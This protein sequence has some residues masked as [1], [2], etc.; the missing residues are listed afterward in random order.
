[1]ANSL[2][3]VLGR[4]VRLDRAS[5]LDLATGDRVYL[6]AV[7][8]GDGA[9]H[10]RRAETAAHVSALRIAGM[11]PLVDYGLDGGGEWIEAY[12]LATADAGGEAA[13]SHPPPALGALLHAGGCEMVAVP[14]ADRRHGP[15][16]APFVPMPLE[17]VTITRPEVGGRGRQPPVY[18]GT[19]A[20]ATALE[21]RDELDG[22]VEWLRESDAGP[23]ARILRVEA[24]MGAGRRT[25]FEGIA[26]EVRLAGFVPVSSLLCR[27]DILSKAGLGGAVLTSALRERHIAV[28]EARPSASS[29]EVAR[30]L[31]RLNTSGGR[32]HALVVCG[33]ATG[34][35]CAVS[36]GP[37]RAEQL[38]RSVLVAGI[39]EAR[40][41]GAIDEALGRSGGWPGAFSRGVRRALGLR[42]PVERYPF[43]RSAPALVREGAPEVARPAALTRDDGGARAVARAEQWV[44]R[45]RHATAERLLRRTIGYLQ[46][47]RRAG[48]EARAQIALGRLLLARERRAGARA[49]FDASRRRF[50]QVRDTAGVVLA[51][52]HQGHASIEDGAL[53][54]A[55]SVLR[56]AE[57][58]A[59]HARLDDLRRDARLLLARCLF[60]QGRHDAAWSQVEAA[61]AGWRRTSREAEGVAESIGPRHAESAWAGVLGGW[62]HPPGLAAVA[63]EIGVRLA[64][65]RHDAGLA[66]R[67]LAAA[68]ETRAEHGPMH[69]GTLVAL[70]LLVQGALG[71]TGGVAA[72]AAA[73]LAL[74]RHLHAPLAAREVR[75]AQIEAL[76]EARACGPAAACLRKLSRRPALA[77]SGL[78]RLR[79]Q[80][81]SERL[82]SL[83]RGTP[84][85]PATIEGTVDTSA[86]VRI[87]RHCHEAATEADAVAGVCQTVRT[88]LGASA[89]TAFVRVGGAAQ[90]VSAAGQRASRPDRAERAM[91]SLL[92]V[93]PEPSA[94]GTEA[95]APVRYGGAPVGSIVVRWAPGMADA[96][97]PRVRGVLAAASAAIGPA[98][99]AVAASAQPAEPT[100]AGC[101]DIGGCSPAMVEVRRQVARA[102]AA[103]YP[104]LILGEIVR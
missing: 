50:D 59:E 104:V 9:P 73:G 103:P 57:V 85:D 96:G 20:V 86:V 90:L 89:V 68:G 11:L 31:S 36:L 45:G 17:R 3:I 81:L 18:D 46:R 35:A 63:A 79:L 75:L 27:D 100:A 33:E 6:R 7:K 101:G 28:L 78:A 14:D 43:S 34:G 77:V 16:G 84:G 55:E 62:P 40:A 29:H 47:R 66:A 98:L 52:L 70:R 25:F 19:P 22:V 56:T 65:A 94:A 26:R 95:A 87:L 80:Q 51:L 83:E 23:G 2:D 10:I 64:L 93:G 13:G 61:H 30:F 4:F 1:V 49:A 99:A 102:A 88:S 72:T 12:G 5:G 37:M 44:A 39:D 60:W 21:R 38:R 92:V 74:M 54:E 41:Q 24:P 58:G 8:G 91:A 15:P 82:T 71:E 48:D 53:D 67:R 97:H 76:I 32:S 42:A 69:A